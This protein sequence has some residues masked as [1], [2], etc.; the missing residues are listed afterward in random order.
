V[1][2]S[3]IALGTLLAG[4]RMTGRVA[5]STGRLL[6]PA[7]R[8][9]LHPPLVPRRWQLGPRLDA[10][11]RS[12]QEERAALL[13]DAVTTGA[14]GA[15]RSLDLVLPLLDLTPLVQAVLA[16][17]DLD[18]VSQDALDGLDLPAVVSTALDGL[19]LTTLVVDRVELGTVVT[20]AL[21]HLDLTEVVVSRVDLERVVT[22]A[23]DRMDLTALVQQRVALADIAEQVVED[24]D[25]PEIIRESTG[26]VASEAVRSA[27]MQS[28][29]AD[30]MV[31]RLADRM[32][33]WLR[34]RE[35]S[36][37]AVLEGEQPS[38][39]ADHQEP[40]R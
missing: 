31:S 25:L 26:S 11:G 13:A 40:K 6:A 15:Q 23:L 33:L 24:I 30:E 32:L 36:T 19:D 1:T 5:R 9:A 38:G 34:R 10:W 39:P 16:R 18:A 12:W 7:A 37:D 27:R 2:G 17:L 4:G 22:A 20:S 29:E 14:A 35:V 8:V 21:D 28:V 3:D